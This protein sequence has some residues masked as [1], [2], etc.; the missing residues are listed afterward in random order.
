MG[1]KM[2]KKISKKFIFITLITIFVAVLASCSIP[3]F[4]HENLFS[5]SQVLTFEHLDEFNNF[6]RIY[7]ADEY[8]AVVEYNQKNISVHQFD[9]NNLLIDVYEIQIDY[10]LDPIFDVLFFYQDGLIISHQNADKTELYQYSFD[11]RVLKKIHEISQQG[12]YE[13][14]NIVNIHTTDTGNYIVLKS[15]VVW[16]GNGHAA[17]DHV[18]IEFDFEWEVNDAI[19]VNDVDYLGFQYMKY[20]YADGLYG[21]LN[22]ND[23]LS[24]FYHD[25]TELVEID[26][27]LD[28]DRCK[29]IAV[30]DTTDSLIVYF[31]QYDEFD[32]ERSISFVSVSNGEIVSTNLVSLGY[33]ATEYFTYQINEHQLINTQVQGL[34]VE[35]SRGDSFLSI[36]TIDINEGTTNYLLTESSNT[37]TQAIIKWN[38]A[39][40]YNLMTHQVLYV[41]IPS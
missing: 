37:I 16:D 14:Y 29:V 23:S 31:I 24:I 39:Y 3:V 38:R 25:L 12:L 34:S 22:Q 6:Y 20:Y 7:T 10:N 9:E 8:L 18:I 27:G 41:D 2:I 19:H 17:F 35:D 28:C 30:D 21:V 33:V 4:P 36:I 15:S 13:K 32:D 5:D 1:D 26:M 11:I 40:T